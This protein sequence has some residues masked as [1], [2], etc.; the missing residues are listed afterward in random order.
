[1]GSNLPKV[2]Y[3]AEPPWGS[4][5]GLHGSSAP[6]PNPWTVLSLAVPAS[7]G[8]FLGAGTEVVTGPSDGRGPNPTYSKGR[9][10]LQGQVAAV[11][12]GRATFADVMWH[13][14]GL[15]SGVPKVVPRPL[16]EEGHV[17]WIRFS[18]PLPP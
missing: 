4:P 8:L 12:W 16:L 10:L 5:L 14:S 1:M 6:V 11:A 13:E 2:T 7:V 15:A 3:L 9:G 17:G 18:L